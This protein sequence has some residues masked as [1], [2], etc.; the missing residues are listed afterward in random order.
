[1]TGYAI[2]YTDDCLYHHGVKGQRWGVRRYQNPDGSLTALGK[3]RLSKN[4]DITFEKGLQLYGV[5]N[6][7]KPN[8][9]STYSPDKEGE[10]SEKKHEGG[11]A[12]STTGKAFVNKYVAANDIKLPSVKKQIK[13][14][15]S[16]LK[17]PEVQKEIVSQALRVGH[18]RENAISRMNRI[19]KNK[20]LGRESVRYLIEQPETGATKKIFE[21]KLRE[22]GYNAYRYMRDRDENNLSYLTTKTKMY[23]LDADKN[24]K[25]NDSHR[26]TREEYA[27]AY[28]EAYQILNERRKKT[29]P[30]LASDASFEKTIETG[31]DVYDRMISVYK[32]EQEEFRELEELDKEQRGDT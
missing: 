5:S 22:S 24:I 10:L 11:L 20:N 1:M 31:K 26:L 8:S 17:D 28:A 30:R 13:I 16:I 7:K 4:G 6:T 25:L 14:E 27:K 23:I 3:K 21:N 29:N 15:T 19:I 18:K 9:S 32:R 2:Q 12:I